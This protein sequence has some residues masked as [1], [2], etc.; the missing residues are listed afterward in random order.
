M[1]WCPRCRRE[2]AN[3]LDQC[4]ECG[5]E[6]LDEVPTDEDLLTDVEWVTVAKRTGHVMGR[7]IKQRLESA[8]I[9][10]IL[11][12]AGFDTVKLYEGYDGNISV[13]RRFFEEA[14]ALVEDML[15]GAEDGLF[16]DNCNTQVT[17]EDLA[18]P[19]CGEPFVD[20]DASE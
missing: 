17:E 14:Q 1:T 5:G 12:G 19:N 18:C 2:H 9:P 10:V 6:L 11:T 3:D 15:K 16:C 8:D 13:P 4:P 7:L 20:E